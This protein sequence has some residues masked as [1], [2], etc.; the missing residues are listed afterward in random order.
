MTD[1]HL[2]YRSIILTPEPESYQITHP[3][4]ESHHLSR[5]AWVIVVGQSINIGRVP[6]LYNMQQLRRKNDEIYWKGTLV[7][8]AFNMIGRT[9]SGLRDFETSRP[10]GL[11][12]DGL[13]CD[14][15]LSCCRLI[16]GK[17]YLLKP[18]VFKTQDIESRPLFAP[19]FGECPCNRT[20]LGEK[21][22]SE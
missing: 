6:S 17:S 16:M 2:F 4:K 5:A 7:I 1:T 20:C 13:W 12:W 15:A 9:L 22:H 3:A 14:R 10:A 19:P 11:R 18:W 21:L 8:S